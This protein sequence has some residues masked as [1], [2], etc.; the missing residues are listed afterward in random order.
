MTRTRTAPMLASLALVVAITTTAAPA[1][2]AARNFEH[3]IS[4]TE[5]IDYLLALPEGYSENGEAWPLVLFLHGAGERGSDLERVKLHGPPKLI[6]A[7][8]SI[9]AIVVSPQ[10]PQDQWW[11]AYA[12]TLLA[13]LDEVTATYNV[14]ADRVYIT[15][16]SMGGFGTWDLASREPDRFAAAAPICGGGMMI[17]AYRIGTSLPVWAFH[18]EA[19]SVVPVEESQRMVDAMQRRGGNARLTVYPG[20]DH[21]SW[22]QTYDDPAFWEWLFAQSR[23]TD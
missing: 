17:S 9:P 6:A 20:V 7:G 5:T 21:D 18:G 2:Q 11:N 19:D 4:R 16:L 13:L 22:T 8:Q 14:D 1:Q 12:E 15:G 3:Q 10:C 23:T